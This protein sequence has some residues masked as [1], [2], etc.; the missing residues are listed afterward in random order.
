MPP[1]VL[2]LKLVGTLLTFV[3]VVG[4]QEVPVILLAFLVELVL[5]SCLG[6]YL[7]FFLGTDYSLPEPVLLL[8][9]CYF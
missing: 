3:P 6:D 9:P 5:S 1:S 8:G 2:L 4:W 7:H